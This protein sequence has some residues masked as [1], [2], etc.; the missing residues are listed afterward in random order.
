MTFIH[1]I[2]GAL[3][4]AVPHY[5]GHAATH[6]PMA[7]AGAALA[8]GTHGGKAFL[9]LGTTATTGGHANVCVSIAGSVGTVVLGVY[10]CRKCRRGVQVMRQQT[11]NDLRTNF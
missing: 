7:L 10:G 4:A 6:L 8:L 2:A 5:G 9:R 1:P 11:S 3:A